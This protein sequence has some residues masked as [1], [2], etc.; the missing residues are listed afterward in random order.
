MTYTAVLDTNSLAGL[1][2]NANLIGQLQGASERLIPHYAN[3]TKASGGE[4][5]GVDHIPTWELSGDESIFKMAIGSDATS[6]RQ[7]GD[8]VGLW[9]SQDLQRVLSLLKWP[10]LDC[11]W[12]SRGEK[13]ARGGFG[14]D[15]TSK[16]K[17]DLTIARD[18]AKDD[19]NATSA[20]STDGPYC[21]TYGALDYSYTDENGNVVVQAIAWCARSYSYVAT[22]D[23]VSM[24]SECEADLYFDGG[25]SGTDWDRD[26][27]GDNIEEDF[28]RQRVTNISDEGELDICIGDKS[29]AMPE[30]NDPSA[31]VI[32]K[33]RGYRVG[34]PVIV[35]KP[36]FNYQSSP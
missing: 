10:I 22:I 2:L 16:D 24:P 6:W 13:N 31:G 17:T 36:D 19:F 26:D 9:C 4:F 12:D 25:V 34:G 5:V 3:H 11:S 33:L 28:V 21:E 8:R 32:I 18:K 27:N 7:N 23:E 35:A 29:L 15:D 14:W 20:E 1:P 30:W